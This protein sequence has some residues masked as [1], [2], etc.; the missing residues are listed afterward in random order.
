MDA[1]I[2]STRADHPHGL[3]GDSGEC[4]LKRRLNGGPSLLNLPPRELGSIVLNSKSHAMRHG[5]HF[6]L[7]FI[8]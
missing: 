2:R 7:Q 4:L 1:G 5:R 8:H 6:R 3:I